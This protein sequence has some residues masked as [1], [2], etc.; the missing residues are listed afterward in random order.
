[1]RRAKISRH[2]PAAPVIGVNISVA[3]QLEHAGAD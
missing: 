1:M 3:H 2:H